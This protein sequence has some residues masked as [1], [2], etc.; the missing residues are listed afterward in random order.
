MG[1]P[2]NRWINTGVPR[3]W[4]PRRR[5]T[6][7][8]SRCCCLKV[9]TSRGRTHFTLYFRSALRLW[10]S[11]NSRQQHVR[12]SHQNLRPTGSGQIYRKRLPH[13]L[14]HTGNTHTYREHSHI[15]GTLTHTGNTHTYREHS[16]I[17]WLLSYSNHTV[18]CRFFCSPSGQGRSQCPLLG[19]F[20]GT[21]ALRPVARR[22]TLGHRP[23][24]QERTHTPRPSCVL[25][26]RASGTST[27]SLF[28]LPILS[29]LPVYQYF[30]F[31]ST[32]G[33]IWFNTNG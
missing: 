5:D 15:Q 19:V 31:I 2:W 4:S 28:S 7:G 8:C 17:Q 24:R 18:Y 9:I 16:H 32:S 10:G 30:R 26:R 25:R 33:F 11:T 29:L 14:T 13:A 23:H 21:T 22:E 27:P 12:T 3:W 6:S 1:R 20:E